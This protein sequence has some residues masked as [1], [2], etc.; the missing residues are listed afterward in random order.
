MWEALWHFGGGRAIPV[1]EWERQECLMYRCRPSELDDE[2]NYVME[3]YTF[4]AGERAR[5]E[6]GPK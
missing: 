6:R 1:E 5:I 3:L 4:L 2:D